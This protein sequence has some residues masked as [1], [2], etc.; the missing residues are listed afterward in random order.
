MSIQNNPAVSSPA[1]ISI[2]NKVIR[3]TFLLLSLTFLFSAATAY[4]AFI[5]NARPMGLLLML[6]GMFGLSYLVNR[7]Q[8]SAWGIAAIFAFTGFMG[9]MLGP[10][11][12]MY[13]HAYSNG[14]QLVA[15][16]MGTTGI[17][18][19]ALSGYALVS[20]KDYNYLG[21]FI[22]VLSIVAFLGG[23]AAILFNMPAVQLLVSGVFALVSSAYILF[24]M[25]RL[26]NGGETNYIAATITLYIAIF[27]LFLSLLRIF[28][29]FSGNRN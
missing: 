11:I 8:D 12:N 29:A 19:F 25:S 18:F 22:F 27:N 6:V 15:T 21:G 5:T 4:Y 13:I 9:Y 24:T 23:L 1:H 14:G 28:A 26:V 3:N 20:R 10:I 2:T 7:L 16:A 17:I